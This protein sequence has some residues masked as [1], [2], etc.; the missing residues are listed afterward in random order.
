[1]IRNL[2]LDWSGTLVDDFTATL[3]ATNVVFEAHGKSAFSADDFRRDFRLP[4][5]EFYEEFLPEQ[6]LADL[7][8]LFKEAFFEAEHLVQPLEYTR[9]FLEDAKQKGLR[10]FVLSSMNEEALLRQAESF[11]LTHYFE[12][13][14]AGVLDKREKMAEVTG[15]YALVSAETAYVGDMVHDIHAAQSGGVVSVAVLS[16]YDP[17][18]RLAKAFPQVLLPHVGE[19]PALCVP[20]LQS[21]RADIVVRKLRLPVF[22]G[23]PDEEREKSQDIKVSL[24][25]ETRNGISGLGDEIMGTID[26]YEVTEAIK[27]LVG[28]RPRKLIETLAEEIAVLVVGEFGARAVK[29]EV[30]KP[31]LSNCEGVVVTTTLRG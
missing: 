29:V 5:P 9:K 26:Y 31:I 3:V 16:G 21:V 12:G 13:I 4:Y 25:I 19:L 15:K 18:E 27:A 24:T 28:E 20:V 2:I 6:S 30:E 17:V 1:M 8:V 14:Y 7:E 22:I 23:V 11:G 10:L